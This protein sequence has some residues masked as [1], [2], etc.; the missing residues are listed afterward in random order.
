MTR[1]A[2]A[3]AHPSPPPAVPHSR[4]SVGIAEEE[5]ARR[6][7]R[8]GRLAPGAEAARGEAR[9]ARLS[10]GAG[11][12]LLS[13]GTSA[14]TLAIQALAIEPGD[15]VAIP[16]YAC[17]A[18]L[19]AVRNAGAAPLV[20][21][22]DPDTLA[23]DA[24]DIPRRGKARAAIVVHPF[25]RPVRLDAFRSLDLLVVEDCAQAIGAVDRGGPVGSRGDVAVFSFAP[26]K[27]LTCGGPGGGLA[28]RDGDVVEAARDLAGHDE[29]DDDR[30]RLNA[31]M[32][33]LQAAVAV[34]QMDRL[35]E[36]I[37]RRDLL[38]R[39]YDE[40]LRPLGLE[41]PAPASG[42]RPI[43]YRYLV[44]VPEAG[45]LVDAL[46]AA[47]IAARRPVYEPLH[48]LARADGSFP[49][50]EQAQRTLVSLPLYPAL[51][52]QEAERVVMEVRRCLS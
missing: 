20:C 21:D 48:R 11:A 30:R 12:V 23:L 28:S 50:A 14:L 34:V 18:L 29:K 17:A 5:A 44:R 27:P 42:T 51:T 6:V 2:L 7:L 3:R 8:S 46:A 43:V 41:R 4:P 15:S 33:D 26:T 37:A 47:G 38:A 25:G 39:L 52:D 19:H 31:L 32:G 22:I 9:L 16:S 36:F 35:P 49:E 24:N 45:R 1:G 10:G 40:R 13:S